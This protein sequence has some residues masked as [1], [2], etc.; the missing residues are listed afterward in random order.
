MQP[1]VLMIAYTNYSTDARVQKE[2]EALVSRRMPV[3]F[4]CLKEKDNGP[5]STVNGVK[6]YYVPVIRYRGERKFSYILSYLS[7]FFLVQLYSTV[8][9]FKNRY[10]VVHVNNMPDFLVF[11]AIIPK[12][13]GAKI[14]L[15]IH[16]P[17]PITFL[18]KFNL[19]KSS[20]FYKLL[21]WEE[22]LS[23]KFADKIITAHSLLKDEVLQND[24]ISKK[25]ID[26]ILNFAD[27]KKFKFINNYHIN[28]KLRLIYHGTIA[29]RFGLK[30]IIEVMKD[31]NEVDFDF[32]IIGSGDYSTEITS[33]I[34][35]LNL[36][37]RIN[38]INESFPVNKLPEILKEF[39]LGIVTY[40]LS[41]AT[42][43]ML[44]VKFLELISL[45]IPSIVV[46][47]KV[48]SHYFTE[49]DAFFYDNSEP[50]SLIKIIANISKKKN[51][52]FEKRNR[53]LEIRE[54][55]FWSTE[56]Q[57]YYEIVQNLI[58]EN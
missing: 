40:E 41:T 35:K 50:D 10:K 49:E 45:G 43:Y 18:T 51:L 3:D 58:G 2:A 55:Y 15:D 24:G 17:L 23:A 21:I 48:I 56:A 28:G 53:L 1:K 22:R 13:F 7:F 30:K 25:K 37:N 54:K 16:D 8:L 29:E 9:Y 4:I 31:L 44:P 12:L 5:K 46:K 39:N 19:S 27:E 38:F 57:K 52:L 6:F 33:I 36:E 20:L 11:A 47:N 34:K 32:T 26:D 14:I 42:E